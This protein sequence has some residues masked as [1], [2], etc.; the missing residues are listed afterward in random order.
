MSTDPD[1]LLYFAP[2]T[3]LEPRLS[4]ADARKPPPGFK[5]LARRPQYHPQRSALSD[6]RRI[7]IDR[8]E[9]T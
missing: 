5:A 7:Q 9:N 3:A 6:F 4:E 8:V 1:R 2:G